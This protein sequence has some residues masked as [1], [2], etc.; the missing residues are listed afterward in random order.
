[1]MTQMLSPTDSDRI[2]DAVDAVE[3]T[4]A[5]QNS[6][7]V[8]APA[9]GDRLRDLSVD[10]DRSRPL[11]TDGSS[12]IHRAGM[13]EPRSIFAFQAVLFLSASRAGMAWVCAAF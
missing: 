11:S 10:W 12:C 2:R 1:M 7:Y 5:A 4:T 3:A 6:S 9:S 8:V 13:R